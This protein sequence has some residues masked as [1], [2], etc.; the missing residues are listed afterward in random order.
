MSNRSGRKELIDVGMIG[1][2]EIMH[3]KPDMKIVTSRSD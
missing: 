2:N 1:N 3:N